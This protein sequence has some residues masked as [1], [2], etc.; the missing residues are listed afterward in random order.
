MT[1]GDAKG[2]G[3]FDIVR[4]GLVQAALGGIVV[5]TT[6]TLN[7]VM[8]VE[9]GLATVIPGLLVG[10]HYAIQFLRPVIGYGADRGRFC[11]PWIL[12]GMMVLALGAVMAASA[13]TVIAGGSSFGYV[14]SILGFLSVGLGV[15]MAG[16]T[17][18]ALIARTV[19]EER[20]PAAATITWV[21]MIVGIIIS[22]GTAGSAL[23]P[24]SHDQLLRV[25]GFVTGAAVL[26]SFLAVWG[27]ERRYK[28]RARENLSAASDPAEPTSLRSALSLVWQEDAARSFTIFVFLSMLA[29]SAQDLILEPYTGL[30]FGMT[31]GES[32]S[33]S[34]TQHQGVLLGLLLVGGLGSL[35]AVR[36]RVPLVA[37]TMIGCV[38]SAIGLGLIAAGGAAGKGYPIVA[39]VFLLGIGNGIFAVGAIGSMF[40]LASQGGKRSEGIRIGLWGAAQATAFATGGIVA[41][42]LVD[43]LGFFEI[44]SMPAYASVFIL[45]GMLFLYS[46]YLA[47]QLV[48][49]HPRSSAGSQPNTF[50]RGLLSLE[51]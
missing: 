49:R 26:V 34:A 29:Y 10:L 30:V 45:E 35:A 12:G 48:R 16:T 22:A 39:C 25:T 38:I 3:W 51:G 24:Y 23:D 37:W 1:N 28:A 2:L 18:L 6:A 13:V 42:G 17:L 8:V 14:L 32:T 46:A 5:L 15:G 44:G 50:G 40:A 19:S 36:K 9:L 43:L 27:V 11:T 41:T 33:L 21:L 4:L 7:R 47:L 31:V 20:R